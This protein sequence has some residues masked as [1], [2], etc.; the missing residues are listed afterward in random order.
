MGFWWTLKYRCFP[1][2]KF[3]GPKSLP[4]LQYGRLMLLFRKGLQPLDAFDLVAWVFAHWG[5][6]VET[7]RSNSHFE[8]LS[9]YPTPGFIWSNADELCEWKRQQQAAALANN[10]QVT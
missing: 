2:T 7:C 10:E 8:G 5:D 6:I 9:T 4:A 1:K 3:Y